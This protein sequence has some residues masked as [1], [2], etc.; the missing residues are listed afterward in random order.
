M[1]KGAARK[2]TKL[3][4][5]SG[6]GCHVAQ[7]AKRTSKQIW[8]KLQS[9]NLLPPILKQLGE[10]DDPGNNVGISLNR[11]LLGEKLRPRSNRD[12]FGML[13]KLRQFA[14]YR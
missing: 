7:L 8:R 1:L 5:D 9:D 11:L 2:Q 3:G 14:A 12:P 10:F 13:A 6:F 4:I